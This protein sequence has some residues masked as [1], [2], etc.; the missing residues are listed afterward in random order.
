MANKGEIP[1]DLAGRATDL[2]AVAAANEAKRLEQQK[3]KEAEARVVVANWDRKMRRA[4]KGIIS[5]P[6]RYRMMRESY[7]KR[8]ARGEA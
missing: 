6:Q 2:Q 7:A 5:S 8:E 1:R 3:R 4:F